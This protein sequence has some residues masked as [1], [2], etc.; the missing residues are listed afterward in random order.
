MAGSL[1]CSSSKLQTDLSLEAH[2]TFTE[3]ILITPPM[4]L[5][6]LATIDAVLPLDVLQS[7]QCPFDLQ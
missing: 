2:S 4:S 7:K 6:A 5:Q 1:L 3:D